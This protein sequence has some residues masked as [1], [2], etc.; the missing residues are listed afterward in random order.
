MMNFVDF[1]NW[2]YAD[3]THFL[4]F[5]LFALVVGGVL[6]PSITIKEKVECP[7]HS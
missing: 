5:L 6:R 7:E 4:E 1:L 2:M 3:W